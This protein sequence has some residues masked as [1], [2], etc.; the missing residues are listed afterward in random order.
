MKESGNILKM[1]TKFGAP[2]QYWLR[3]SQHLLPLNEFIGRRIS[4]QYEHQINCIECGR[5]T[6]KSFGQGF[7][8][9][10]FANSPENS[11][12]I[13]HPEKCR[14]HLNEGRNVEWELA[15]HVQPHTV[16]LA[17]S[18]DIK[19]GVTRDTQIPTRWIDQG[20]S[21]A[22]VFARTL[23]RWQAGMIE[24]ALK[25]HISDKTNWQRMLK[26]E[27]SSR[28]LYEVKDEMFRLLPE[29]WQPFVLPGQGDMLE[30]Q[31][32]VLRFPQK[33]K[34]LNFD[35][36]PLIEGEL[37]GIKG[38]Y[39]LFDEDRVINIRSQSGYMVTFSA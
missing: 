34:S 28:S 11:D 4:L 38:Q 30:L 37:L 22:I 35:K 14:G 6:P 20:A 19:V 13:I 31:Y 27:I 12:C 1:K 18:N 24:V 23:N 16:Y 5:K 3:L 29:E 7:C 8:Y 10:C 2:V 21:R 9:P 25:Q 33:V 32:P 36:S 17:L 15:H 26:N 39:L